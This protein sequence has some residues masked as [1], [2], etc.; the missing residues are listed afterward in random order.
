MACI[1]CRIINKEIPTDIVYEDK[2]IVAFKDIHPVAKVHILIIPKK[3]IESVA[4]LK[5]SDIMLIGKMIWQAKILAEKF[6][7]NKTGYK[8]LFNCGKDGGQV[9]KHIHLHL[10]G[11]Q[12]L[13]NWPI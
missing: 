7:I 12:K 11:G 8:L 13:K 5:S 2:E 6:G 4:K 3:H 1:F 10:I 9:I